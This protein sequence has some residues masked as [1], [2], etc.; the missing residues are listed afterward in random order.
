MPFSNSKAKS[1]CPLRHHDFV[2]REIADLLA[3]G[4]IIRTE[5]SHS[6]VNPLNVVEHTGKV[7]LIPDLVY[8]NYFVFKPTFLV[9]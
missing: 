3:G 6:V 7:R 5:R 2:T 4:S 8:I 1:S 9:K